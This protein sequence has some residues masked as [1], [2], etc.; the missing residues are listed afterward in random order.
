MFERQ[1]SLSANELFQ[2]NEAFSTNPLQWFMFA[3]KKI[4]DKNSH[5][6]QIVLHWNCGCGDYV[7]MQNR[8]LFLYPVI[9]YGP[10]VL[11]T[12]RKVNLSH[13]KTILSESL[14]IRIHT[15]HDFCSDVTYFVFTVLSFSLLHFRTIPREPIF[16]SLASITFPV[17]EAFK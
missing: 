4:N 10:I 14:T 3:V 11:H 6:I 9:I 12:T 5:Y 15:V 16:I 1:R 2:W 17:P 7:V 8:T 13:V